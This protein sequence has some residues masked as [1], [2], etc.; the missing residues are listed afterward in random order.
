[1]CP[2][3]AEESFIGESITPAVGTFDPA[4][5]A[6]GEPG[7]PRAFA[8]RGRDY[9]VAAVLDTWRSTSG[10]R[11]GSDEQYV[12]KHWYRIRTCGGET[13]T[14][15]FD[16]QPRRGARRSRARWTRYSVARA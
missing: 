11:S 13:M 4:G 1:M 3:L 15:Y 12:R 8:W 16:R 5:M 14:L 9:Q 10:C 2:G 7:L 6:R